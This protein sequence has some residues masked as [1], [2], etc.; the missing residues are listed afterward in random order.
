MPPTDV[1]AGYPSPD[2][3]DIVYLDVEDALIAY[4]V[5]VGCTEQQA[6]NTLVAE[7]KL[8]AA[9]ER[10]RNYALY[11]EASIELQAAVLAHGVINAHAFV[12]GNKRVAFLMMATFLR[13]NGF[14][15]IAPD[16]ECFAWMIAMTVGLT[17][18]QLA[19]RMKPHIQPSRG[20][21]AEPSGQDA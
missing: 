6:R 11:Q 3:S 15:I 19:S 14:E 7:W 4:S 2:E 13:Y 16:H 5:T 9:L 10:P 20:S 21:P 18:D 8:A 12:D 1:V 17:P